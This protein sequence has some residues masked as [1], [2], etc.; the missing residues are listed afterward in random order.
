MTLSALVKKF[1][2]KVALK[3][4]IRSLEK[5]TGELIVLRMTCDDAPAIEQINALMADKRAFEKQCADTLEDFDRL[6]EQIGQ[7][8]K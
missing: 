4:A 6:A 1:R 7:T 8:V 5:R 3:M 2:A